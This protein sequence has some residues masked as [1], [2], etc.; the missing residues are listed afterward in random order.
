MEKIIIKNG[1]MKS[2]DGKRTILS[3]IKNQILKGLNEAGD[4]DFII[5]SDLDEIPNLK[6]VDLNQ[7]KSEII[8]FNQV[9]FHYRLNLYLKELPWFGSKCCTKKLL[10][11]PQW[12]RNIKDKKY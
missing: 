6:N 3:H 11:S 12:L 2:V 5:V 1:T 7:H 10:K 9:F 8:V 4:D